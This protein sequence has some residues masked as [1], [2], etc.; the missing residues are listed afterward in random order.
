MYK[1]LIDRGLFRIALP[2]PAG[3]EFELVGVVNPYGCSA[4]DTLSVYRRPLPAANLRFLSSVMWDGR[5]SSPQTGTQKITIATNPADLLADLD[6][7]AADAVSGHA[8]AAIPLSTE[9]RRA[10]V[11]FE[12]GLSTAQAIDSHAGRLDEG[13]A[14]GGPTA[15]ALETTP[16]FFVGINDPLG[17]NPSGAAFISKIFN[18]FDPWNHHS[19]LDVSN[20]RASIS[21]GEA[22]FNSKPIQITGVAGLND[23]LGLAVIPGTC[24][25]CHD[26]PNVGNHSVAVALNIGVGDMTSPL[27]LSYLPTFTFQ[28]NTTHEIKTTTDPGRALITG[29]WKDLGKMK[30]PV[31]R[32]LA[33]RAPYFHNGSAATLTNVLEFYERRFHLQFTPQEKMDLIAFLNA[34]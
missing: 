6:H 16:A 30:G 29:L 31:L 10:I 17:G 8:Q 5:E 19:N 28:N 14:I 23:D 12:M 33:A 4:P 7:Q 22:L 27:D 21:R 18:L 26:S 1:K 15:L 3:A 2:V 25:T 32:G 9:Q 24:G 34:L 20:R 13:G 11:S